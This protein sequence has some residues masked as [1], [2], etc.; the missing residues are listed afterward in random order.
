[1]HHHGLNA[2]AALSLPF[3]PPAK[4]VP[5]EGLGRRSESLGKEIEQEDYVAAIEEA[6]AG[7][8][9]GELR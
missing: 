7:L 8:P 3:E 2:T 1:M 6:V 4:R 9:R 5:M